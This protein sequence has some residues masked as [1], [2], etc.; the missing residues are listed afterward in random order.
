MLGKGRVLMTG[1][2]EE[3][4]TTQNL[5][6]RDFIEGKAPEVEDVDVLLSTS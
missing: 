4:R 6:V 5:Y 2:P 1:T 3:F